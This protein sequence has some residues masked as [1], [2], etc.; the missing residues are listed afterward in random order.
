VTPKVSVITPFVGESDYLADAIE[1]VRAQTLDD[2]ELLLV[3]DGRLPETVA[4][5]SS[6]V[7]SEPKRVRLLSSGPGAGAAAARNTGIVAARGEYLAFLDADDVFEPRK[8]EVE[9]TLLEA[10][11]RAAM[12]YGPT[13]W[14]FP[15]RW[16]RNR[17]ERLGV[18]LDRVHE[19]PRLLL[20]V[21]VRRCG[22]IPCTC[23]ILIRREIAVRLGGFEER[24]RLYEDQTLLAKV[25]LRHPVYV[26]SR[27]HARYRNHP[28]STSARAVANGEYQPY[29][30]HIARREFLEWLSAHVTESGLE[31]PGLAGEIAVESDRD[32]S[33]FVSRFRRL[34]R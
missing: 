29:R 23:G 30:P 31:V 28:A 12:L 25:L 9:A 3:D 33:R 21:I 13:R 27:P 8:L 24:F 17:T 1:S 20:D 14:W 19:P 26:S 18:E 10:H 11:P 34:W 16:W 4:I 22:D 15:A 2:W 7:R 5:A 6:Y 32:V